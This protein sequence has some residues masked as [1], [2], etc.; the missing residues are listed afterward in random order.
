MKEILEQ[1]MHYYKSLLTTASFLFFGTLL[2]VSSL[3]PIN[4]RLP[5]DTS[6]DFLFCFIFI[7]LIRRP[8]NVPLISI[9]FVSLLA[10]FL[11]Y[12]PIGLTTLTIVLASE[13][14]RW[15]NKVRE[16]I[17][18]IEE[19]LYVG[20]ILVVTVTAQEVTKFFTVI[21]SLPLGQIINYILLTLLVYPLITLFITV[22]TRVTAIQK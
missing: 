2:V 16:K 10:D 22:I 15:I 20:S 8:Q 11:W 4:L 5:L 3:A 13:F 14:I 1:L 19:F 21:P 17:G 18:L 7:F 6:A 12:R 9:L